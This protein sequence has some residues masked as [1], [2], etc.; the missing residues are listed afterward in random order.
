MKESDCSKDT[1]PPT[2]QKCNVHNPCP[3]TGKVAFLFMIPCISAL[4]EMRRVTIS[5][6][7]NFV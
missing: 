6:L 7:S 5:R 4:Q 2:E 1:K 3:G